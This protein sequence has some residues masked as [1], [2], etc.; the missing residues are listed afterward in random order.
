MIIKFDRTTIVYMYYNNE[1][2]VDLFEY[3][4]CFGAIMTR[5][6]LLHHRITDKHAI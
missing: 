1:Q 3:N 6:F 2:T 4:L 5:F